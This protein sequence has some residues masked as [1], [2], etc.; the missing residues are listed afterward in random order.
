MNRDFP[1]KVKP[2]DFLNQ[3]L[4]QPT[5]QMTSQNKLPHNFKEETKPRKEDDQDTRSDRARE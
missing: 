2:E 5:I 4:S 3:N 1:Q